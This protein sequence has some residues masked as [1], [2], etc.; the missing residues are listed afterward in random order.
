MHYSRMLI[1]FEY[2]NPFSLFL[3]KSYAWKNLIDLNK[4]KNSIL[5]FVVCVKQCFLVI[6]TSNLHAGLCFCNCE[7]LLN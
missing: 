1:Y 5:I 2:I 4:G 3:Y 6:C 7:H